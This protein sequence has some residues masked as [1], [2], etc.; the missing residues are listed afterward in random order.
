VYAIHKQSKYE[1][2][3]QAIQETGNAKETKNQLSKPPARRVRTDRLV[4]ED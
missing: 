4:H 1:T 2:R 3:D